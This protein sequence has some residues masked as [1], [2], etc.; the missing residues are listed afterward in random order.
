VTCTLWASGIGSPYFSDLSG[1]GLVTVEAPE[2][3]S[4]RGVFGPW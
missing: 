2:L 1:A 4:S 3:V